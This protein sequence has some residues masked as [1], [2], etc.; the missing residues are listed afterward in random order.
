MD[1]LF[2]HISE[3][4]TF[5]LLIFG[6]VLLINGLLALFR[7]EIGVGI[8]FLRAHLSGPAAR[9]VGTSHFLIGAAMLIFALGSFLKLGISEDWLP[10]AFVGGFCGTA[11]INIGGLV[12]AS[13]LKRLSS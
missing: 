2:E 3:N 7:G 9:A 12:A 10:W 5:I 1:N 8:L 6:L 11:V 4:I 13:V